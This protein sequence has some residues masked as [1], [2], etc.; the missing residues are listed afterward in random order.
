MD[1]NKKNDKDT[2]KS[3]FM[4]ISALIIVGTIGIFRRY[5]P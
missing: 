3:H 5:I 2:K 4:L 1:A